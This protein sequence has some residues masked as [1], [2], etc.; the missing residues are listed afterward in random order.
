MKIAWNEIKYQPKKFILI[1]VLIVIMM[2]MV[3]FLSGLTNGLGRII[4]AQI[5]T[6]GD[7]Q[8]ILSKDSEGVIPYSTLTSSELTEIEDLH[9]EEQTGLVIQ[10]STFMKEDE[11][12]SQDVT[13]FAMDTYKNLTIKAEDGYVAANLSDNEVILDESYKAKGI[14]VGDTIKDKTSDILLKVVAFAQDAK[15]GHS[16]VAFISSKTLEEMRQ[17]KNPNYTWQPQ[18]IIT[19]QAVTAD[20]LSEQLM[21]SNKQ[22]IINK[23]PGYTATNMILKTM[24]WVLLIASA[25]ILG[26]F[27]Y[28]LALQ[29]LKQFGVLKA[30]GMSMGEIT[31]IQ[32]SQVG[33]LS[34]IGIGIGLGLALALTPFLPV[35]MPFY[36]KAE[37]NAVISVSFIVISIICGALSLL[38]IKKVD[39]IEVIGGN[40]E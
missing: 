30:I 5:D 22:Q 18:A 36:M 16:S 33:I 23:I 31:R 25:A 26:V 20:D 24:T 3:I 34:I 21:V 38:K 7:V 13:F 19:S 17:K 9:L 6:F 29:K 10:R 12:G 37:D 14:H 35:S 4:M 11:E 40:G 27:F 28:I 32:L 15:Y 1:E 8:Y 2:F 39:P